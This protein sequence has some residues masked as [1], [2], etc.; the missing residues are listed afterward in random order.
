MTS[1]TALRLAKASA[2]NSDWP[3]S[4]TQWGLVYTRFQGTNTIKLLK[5]TKFHQMVFSP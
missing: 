1:Q 3:S 4:G 2:I 5:F